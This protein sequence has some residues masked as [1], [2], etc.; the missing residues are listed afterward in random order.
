ML[1]L[2]VELGSKWLHEVAVYATYYFTGSGSCLVCLLF[3]SHCYLVYNA[4]AI[5]HYIPI[6]YLSWMKCAS[7]PFFLH[8]EREG[9]GQPLYSLHGV[10]LHHHPGSTWLPLLSLVL[11]RLRLLVPQWLCTRPQRSFRTGRARWT[12]RWPGQLWDK[13]TIVNAVQSHQNWKET[14]GHGV[15]V[16]VFST[17]L[18]DP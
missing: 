16:W 7:P 3:H 17:G 1:K 12:I 11:F 13:H 15:S 8:Q 5:K 2:K 6:S 9:C 14:E 18:W 4:W 10:Q